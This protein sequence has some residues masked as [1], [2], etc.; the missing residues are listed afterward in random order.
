MLDSLLVSPGGVGRY[1]GTY[2]TVKPNQDFLL[3]GGIRRWEEPPEKLALLLGVLADR[4]HASIGL[5][6]IKVHIR[7]VLPVDSE[8]YVL[9]VSCWVKLRFKVDISSLVVLS[10]RNLGS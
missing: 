10:F 7:D 9:C 5:S 6:H 4:Q 2:T 3:S 8:L 1:D